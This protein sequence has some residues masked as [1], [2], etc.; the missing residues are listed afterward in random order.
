MS[1]PKEHWPEL[2]STN[3]LERLNKEIKRRSRGGGI[4]PI[5]ASIVRLVGALL[6]EQTDEWQVGRRYMS[7]KAIGTVLRRDEPAAV[8][9]CEA[10]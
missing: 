2:A 6:A 9:E 7:L 3:T 8:L 1:F 4:S 5:D 10:A